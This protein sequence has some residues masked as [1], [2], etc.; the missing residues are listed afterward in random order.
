MDERALQFK[1]NAVGAIVVA[2]I[3]LFLTYIF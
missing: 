1:A 3:A 2:G